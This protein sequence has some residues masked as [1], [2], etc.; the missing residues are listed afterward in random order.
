MVTGN[1]KSIDYSSKHDTPVQ[2]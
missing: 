2:V 1:P